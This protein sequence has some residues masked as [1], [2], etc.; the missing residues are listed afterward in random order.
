MSKMKRKEI[1]MISQSKIP[2]NKYL[3][4]TFHLPSN[5]LKGLYRIL[6]FNFKFESF[7]VRIL[8]A[9]IIFCKTQCRRTMCKADSTDANEQ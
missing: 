9:I 4:Y 8:D 3:L 6:K 5:E 7:S 1:F 2:Y